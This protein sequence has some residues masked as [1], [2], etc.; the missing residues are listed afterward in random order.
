MTAKPG[1]TP[2]LFIHVQ[3]LLGIGHMERAFAIASAC[4]DLGFAVTVATGRRSCADEHPYQWV[5]LPDLRSADAGFSVLLDEA[6]APA[7]DSLWAERRDIL[8]D[9]FQRAEP[10]L[11]LVEGFPFARRRFR[12]ELLPLISLARQAGVPIVCSIRDILQPKNDPKRIEE[13]LTWANTCFDLILVHGDPS[14]ARLE[15]SFLAAGRLTTP[16]AY[17]GYVAKPDGPD[18]GA[19]GQD[20]VIVSAGGGAVGASLFDAALAAS[21]LPGAERWHWRLLVGRNMDIDAAGLAAPAHVTIEPARADFRAMLS[22]AAVSVSQAG[23]NT[24]VDLFATGAPAVLCPFAD[25]GQKEQA[26]RADR[27]A[28][29]I[30]ATVL[31]E[32]S[33]TADSLFDAVRTQANRSRRS[34]AID[35]AGAD[36]TARI[37]SLCHEGDTAAAIQTGLRGAE[38]TNT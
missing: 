35:L 8:L 34:P 30:G 21:R 32:G 29:V 20:E 19:A 26:M 37:L 18:D 16:I 36:R 15:D 12:F 23:Y 17:T 25:G 13:C 31:S 2:H 33:V 4:R 11:L 1:M 22:R 9:G 27:M 14:I 5:P 28:S 6:G 10:D 7:T 3:H 38:R 24:A